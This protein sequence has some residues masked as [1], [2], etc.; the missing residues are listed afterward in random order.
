MK[1]LLVTGLLPYNIHQ[2]HYLREAGVEAELYG[3]W[4]IHL[5]N[6]IDGILA[7]KPDLIHLQW[8]ESLCL[9]G[10]PPNM[11]SLEEYPPALRRLRES[12][13]PIL[14]TMHNL[15]P[16]NRRFES[17]WRGL[18]QIF[19]DH[20]DVCCHHSI[21]GQER[22]L[23]TYT[24]PKR[25]RHVILHHGYFD[26]GV[27]PPLPKEQARQ[28]LE[29]PPQGRL[30]LNVGVI[31]PDK[32]I[33]E[34]LDLFEARDREPG[35]L[36]RDRL[37]LAGM[38]FGEYG[39]HIKE[40]CVGMSNVSMMEGFV[41]EQTLSRL[42]NAADLFLFVHGADHLTSGAPHLSQAHLLPA[43]MLD[44]PY[45]REVL[46]DGALYVSDG[47][48]KWARVGEFLDGSA[49]QDLT[50]LRQALEFGRPPWSWKQIALKT[51]QVYMDLLSQ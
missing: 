30:F 26:L 51:Q 37:V 6:E 23:Q 42:I 38:F 27:Y 34:L 21:Q 15:L 32:Q 39:Q 14:W 10:N 43:I 40:R 9:S 31:R 3:K 13:I 2:H 22:V 44:T 46:G 19:A 29:L 11:E 24:F 25:V 5:P 48:E 33:D 4:G 45:N 36:D 12:G 50:G 20:C 1:A 47:P 8:P 7:R 28:V 49:D 17:F 35:N 41:D 16:H 18:Y